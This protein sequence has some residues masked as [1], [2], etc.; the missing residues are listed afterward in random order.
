MIVT[1][2]VRIARPQ[3]VTIMKW[4]DLERTKT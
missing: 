2:S 1:V 3:T 4:R